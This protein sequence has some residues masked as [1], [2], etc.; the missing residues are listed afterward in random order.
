VTGLF[1]ETV[2]D[3]WTTRIFAGS[4]SQSTNRGCVSWWTIGQKGKKGGR[5]GISLT[6]VRR[7]EGKL[8]DRDLTVT[9]REQISDRT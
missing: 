7:F 5:Q 9:Q 3:M 2:S 6:A 4:R 1:R 8:G